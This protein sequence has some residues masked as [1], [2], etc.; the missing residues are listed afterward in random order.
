MFGP[1]EFAD[2]FGAPRMSGTRYQHW[3][4]GTDVVAESGTLH[5]RWNEA[6]KFYGSFHELLLASGVRIFE[7]QATSSFLEKA[8][9]PGFSG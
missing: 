2:T 8:V 4:E 3:H 9:E 5:V 1:A 7:V 6:E